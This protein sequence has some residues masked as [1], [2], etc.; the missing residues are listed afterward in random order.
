[1]RGG[2]RAGT[3]LAQFVPYYSSLY[4]VFHSVIY[5]SVTQA[6]IAPL[7]FLTITALSKYRLNI[8]KCKIALMKIIAN[9]S[10]KLPVSKIT[11]T[12]LENRKH[13][14]RLRKESLNDDILNLVRPCIT[15]P[16]Q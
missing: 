8:C 9:L 15:K 7:S 12:V 10:P 5:N 13:W 2:G 1:M 11:P 6:K 16:R 3:A 14:L 4:T